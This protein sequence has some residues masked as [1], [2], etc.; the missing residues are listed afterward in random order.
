MYEKK[1]EV[2]AVTKEKLMASFWKFYWEKKIEKITVKEITDEA[3]YYRST[4]YDYFI[5][6]YDVL[7]QLETR[8]ILTLKENVQNSLVMKQQKDIIEILANMYET[9]GEYLSILLGKGG[10]PNFHQKL[11]ESLRPMLFHE[12]G[13]SKND[14]YNQLIFEFGIASIISTIG[15]WYDNEKPIT[16]EQLAILI[17]SMLMNGTTP[18]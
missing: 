18:L 16:N 14:V 8:L 12:F 15:H 3:G 17:R 13:L 6:I 9:Q 2:T 10:D 11:K 5:D 7:E 4:F 1:P